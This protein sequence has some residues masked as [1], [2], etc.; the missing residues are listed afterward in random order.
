MKEKD[1]EIV[2]IAG[3]KVYTG[4]E[5][6]HHKDC[7]FYPESLSKIHDTLLDENRELK[8]GSCI[9][10]LVGE[11]LKLESDLISSKSA[12]DPLKIS[13]KN[14][15]QY[16]SKLQ[17]E[18][19]QLE[20]RNCEGYDK[21]V[22]ENKELKEERKYLMITHNSNAKQISKQKEQLDR[23]VKKIKKIANNLLYE[24]P[25]R[26]YNNSQIIAFQ[27]GIDVLEKALIRI[28]EKGTN[29]EK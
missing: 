8:D 20:K 2:C 12:L 3:C 13:N 25:Q 10:K 22:D 19:K 24:F 7:P 17:D 16:I 6:Y 15:Q 4:G 27:R 29:A 1:R 14:L 18:N 28:I 5:I 23:D 11:K 9:S 21:L 26:S